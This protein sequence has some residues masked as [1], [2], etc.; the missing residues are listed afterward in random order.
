MKNHWLCQRKTRLE[1]VR[2]ANIKAVQEE[3]KQREEKRPQPIV[4]HVSIELKPD[5][6]EPATTPLD[7]DNQ[8]LTLL[9]ASQQIKPDRMVEEQ[10]AKMFYKMAE[11]I[12]DHTKFNG[13]DREDAIQ[14]CVIIAF[15]K[16]HRFDY[17]KGKAFN[18]FTTIMYGLL[19]T[20]YRTAWN[21]EELKRRYAKHISNSN[22]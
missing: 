5:K 22:S 6:I 13:V 2:V 11:G 14:E 20:I 4:K 16:L 9:C 1:A 8:T 17:K 7:I 3:V 21:Y 10:L 18:F 19:R 15:E 12:L